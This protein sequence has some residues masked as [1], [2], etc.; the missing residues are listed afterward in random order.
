MRRV[1]TYG[2]SN[3]HTNADPYTNTKELSF[4]LHGGTRSVPRRS[5]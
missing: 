2:Y 5:L 3:T 1:S 4:E